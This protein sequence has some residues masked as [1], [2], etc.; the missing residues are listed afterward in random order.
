[1]AQRDE[2]YISTALIKTR[3]LPN[4]SLLDPW[5]YKSFVPVTSTPNNA[6]APFSS[7]A[8]QNQSLYEI[9]T[10][11]LEKQLAELRPSQP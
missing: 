5:S 3:Y 1:M 6:F 11:T 8:I 2:S 7:I 10:D 9:C 4:P